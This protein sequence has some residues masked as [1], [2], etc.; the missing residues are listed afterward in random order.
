MNI[1]IKQRINFGLL[2]A[3]ITVLSLN[4]MKLMNLTNFIICIFI[5][6]LR[7]NIC[8]YFFVFSEKKTVF[9]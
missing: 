2:I 5:H 3:I 1:Y 6:Y 8:F 7:I 4:L 9:L